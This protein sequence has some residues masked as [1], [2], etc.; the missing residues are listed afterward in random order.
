[1]RWFRILFWSLI[2]GAQAF[3]QPSHDHVQIKRQEPGDFLEVVSAPAEEIVYQAPVPEVW[4]HDTSNP[5]DQDTFAKEVPYKNVDTVFEEEPA[6]AE[7][8]LEEAPAIIEVVAQPA[9][10][11]VSETED[12]VLDPATTAPPDAK[13]QAFL[14]SLAEEYPD[15]MDDI[16]HEYPDLDEYEDYEQDE[17]S[18]AHFAPLPESIDAGYTDSGF[19]EFGDKTDIIDELVDESVVE[20]ILPSG[21]D[22]VADE[23]EE[24]DIQVDQEV[25]EDVHETIQHEDI[26]EEDFFSEEFL[27]EEIIGQ[28]LAGQHV[29]EAIDE[30]II[31]EETVGGVTEF[32]DEEIVDGEVVDKFPEFVGEE[33]VDQ[34]VE[35]LVDEEIISGEVVDE[36][37]VG[38]IVDKFSEED[39]VEDISLEVDVDAVDED[40]LFP[41]N[42][43][44]YLS[45]QRILR[46]LLLNII[47]TLTQLRQIVPQLTTE[48]NDAIQHWKY[49]RRVSYDW[50]EVN[51]DDYL[52]SVASL[53]VV[54]AALRDIE[55]SLTVSI[56]EPIQRLFFDNLFLVGF[57]N[58]AQDSDEIPPFLLGLPAD[59]VGGL[60]H[61]LYVDVTRPL[62]Q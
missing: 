38:E 9:P 16:E 11:P 31:N 62:P 18:L 48:I 49:L 52:E 35:E 54:L 5:S 26:F 25:V 33:I 12:V 28:D 4:N 20:E 34:E 29:T 10:E 59:V 32:I 13:L 41:Q 45:Q 42:T 46:H 24:V 8:V 27:N 1:M 60:I 44:L 39:T 15:M 23:I 22:P 14:K 17:D 30:E 37:I 47:K 40:D 56:H 57:L 51:E 2:S 36:D 61:F 19:P 55:G 21:A 53:R 43:Y 50:G 58:D 6:E 7:V 3:S